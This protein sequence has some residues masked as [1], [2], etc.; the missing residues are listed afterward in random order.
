MTDFFLINS[1]CDFFLKFPLFLTLQIILTNYFGN[2]NQ[3]PKPRP[4]I[5]KTKSSSCAPL[6]SFTQSAKINSMKKFLFLFLFSISINSLFAQESEAEATPEEIEE[7]LQEYMAN[8]GWADSVVSTLT[9]DTTTIQLGDGIATLKV[10]KGHKYLNAKD[11]EMVLTDLWGNPPSESLGMIFPKDSGPMDDASYAI[12][13]TYMEEGYVDDSDAKDLNY[14]ELLETMQEDMG[15]SNE[16]RAEMGYPTIELVGW[17]A[18]PYYDEENKKLHWAKDLIFDGGDVHTL[19]YNIRV[20]G[21]KGFL[22]LNVIGDIAVLP[23]VNANINSILPS[24]DFNDNH[25]YSDFDPD[26]DQ[27]AAYGIGGLI[28][29][30]ILAKAGILAKL[31]IVLAKFWK[32]IA[33]GVVGFFAAFRKFFGKSEERNIGDVS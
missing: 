16:M 17:A 3:E 4:A 20:L 23:D 21:R 6:A 31:G 18:Q 19:N 1:S 30:K 7:A 22:Q 15:E 26:I 5:Q 9:Y 32:I 27:V 13:L 2:Q 33:L 8:Y 28:A 29:G 24:V 11:A 12:N 14:D 25:R 10:P